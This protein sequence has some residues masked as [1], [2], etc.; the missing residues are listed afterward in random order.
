MRPIT[1]LVLLALSSPVTA[2]AAAKSAPQRSSHAATP[3]FA[4]PF[5]EDDV[6]RALA[7]AREQQLPV[8]VEAW[9]PWCHACRSM[10]AYVFTNRALTPQSKRF[11]WL[12]IDTEQAKNAGLRK[13]LKVSALPTYFI[14]HPDSQS[15]AIRWVG[16]A[17]V[18]QLER[19]LDDGEAAVRGAGADAP[20]YQALIEADRLYG[21]EEHAAA[22]DA[23]GRAISLAPAEWP[24]YA[25]AVESRMF[26][27]SMAER[28]EDA[29]HQALESWTRLAKSSSAATLAA[30]GLDAALQ[31][32]ADHPERKVAIARFK[33]ACHSLVGARERFTADDRSGVYFSLE[34]AREDAGDSTGARELM[35]EH[36]AMLDRE[37]AAAKTPHERTVFD[38]HRISLAV[39][40]GTADRIVPAL[41]QSQRDFPDDYNPPARLAIGYRALKKWPEAIKASD[42]ALQ[43]VYGPRQFVVLDA[44]I[45]IHRDM[46]DAEGVR[47]WVS[48]ALARAR[49]MPAEQRSERTVAK[50]EQ[51]LAELPGLSSSR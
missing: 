23:F 21:R 27:L 34:A 22:A 49:A 16:G 6:E 42:R 38:S 25:R 11:V 32:P 41:L 36:A 30:G 37:A 7:L 35:Q 28:H 24:A 10:R 43:L 12:S 5:I 51:Q 45:S 1:M 4:L 17:S 19:L 3:K 40:L 20:A 46:E 39:E 8:F 50:Y 48:E 26:A 15:A 33:S 31:L 29:V 13:Q 2:F 14:M 18:A 9:A 47:H 44:R